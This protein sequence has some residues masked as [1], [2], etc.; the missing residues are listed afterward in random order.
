[1]RRRDFITLL[2]S[3]TVAKPLAVRAQQVERTPVIGFLSIRSNDDVSDIVAAFRQ[4]LNE[5]GYAEGRNVEIEYR[6]ASNQV[7][8]LPGL[9]AELLRRPVSAIAAFG[10][11]PAQ[12]AK[13]ASRTIPIVFLTADDPVMV[14]RDGHRAVA[15]AEQRTSNPARR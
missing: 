12:R 4:G 5:A 6:W 7:D 9:V 11:V 2:G 13:E 10:T 8:R 15:A 3:A 1:M 14:G